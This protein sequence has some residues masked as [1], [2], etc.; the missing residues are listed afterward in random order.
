MSTLE[1][2]TALLKGGHL[3]SQTPVSEEVLRRIRAGV[4]RS[5]KINYKYIEVLLDQ[6]AID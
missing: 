6:D 4:S 2:L 5:T 1:R 3:V